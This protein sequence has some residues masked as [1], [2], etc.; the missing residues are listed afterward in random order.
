M[1]A[2]GQAYAI[3]AP[4]QLSGSYSVTVYSIKCGVGGEADQTRNLEFLP[5]SNPGSTYFPFQ[6]PTV[7]FPSGNYVLAFREAVMPF[8]CYFDIGLTPK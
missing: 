5:A 1:F 2:I 3:S 8:A 7:A 6:D 4:H